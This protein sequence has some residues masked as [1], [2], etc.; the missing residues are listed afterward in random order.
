[1]V[2]RLAQR[3]ASHI[4]AHRLLA[5]GDRAGVAV[6]GG[7]DSVALLRLLI[8]LRDELGLVLS[9]LHFHHQIRGAEADAD[10]QFVTG[11]ARQHQLEAHFAS[12]DAP[13]VSNRE[14]IS[15]EAAGRALRYGCFA[16]LM[17]EG[18]LDKV[19]TAHT[20]DDQAETVLLKLLRGA[21]TRGLAGIYPRVAVESH[22]A[23]AELAILRP[24]LG[25]RRA[26]L[27]EYLQSIGQQ[28]REDATNLDLQHRRNLVR[29]AL[30]PQLERNFNPAAVE[31]LAELAEVA[32]AEEEYW[33]AQVRG[34][35]VHQQPISVNFLRKLP[36]ALQRR[37]VRSAAE[38]HGLSLEFAEVHEILA[39]AEG[40]EREKTVVL[41]RGWQALR[42]DDAIHFRPSPHGPVPDYE[43]SLPAPGRA[44]APEIGV[45]FKVEVVALNGTH[46]G[47]LLSTKVLSSPLTL[48][49]WR[50]GD[51]FW[52]AH[53]RAPRKVKEL[54]QEQH[55][56][57]DQRRAWPV[58]AN[59]DEIVWIRGFPVPEHL[60]PSLQETHAVCIQEIPLH[61]P[62]AQRQ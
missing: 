37:V 22:N 42:R 38:A 6:S 18:R 60:R 41:P 28:W 19:V 4:R 16:N 8:E 48:R 14:G 20:L 39:A 49:N 46:P 43:Y 3:L 55:V 27:R 50:P 47:A 56:P 30:V 52:P 44:A 5:P 53:T 35:V 36:L 23:A 59:G 29:H 61:D 58:I 10:Q 21:G 12:G 34:I 26:E 11:L 1:M 62:A 54:L 17:A 31:R 25:I 7:A 15:L 32:R 40:P 33:T 24:L 45:S 9:V 51:R 13:G 2:H 57:V